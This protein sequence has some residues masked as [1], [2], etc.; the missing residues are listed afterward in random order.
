[1][2]F[3]S[4]YLKSSYVHD[5]ALNFT[6]ATG[7]AG[8]PFEGLTIPFGITYV[9]DFPDAIKGINGA[10]DILKYNVPD[11]NAGI[12]YKGTFGSG[13]KEGAIIYLGF[14][15][16]TARD[17]SIASFMSRALQFFDVTGVLPVTG[18]ETDVKLI[19]N[20]VQ[21]RWTTHTEINTKEFEVEKSSNGV[22]F[23]KIA[24][25]TAAGNSQAARTYSIQDKL[26]VSGIYFYRVKSIDND[27][28]VTYSDVKNVH[29]G[30]DLTNVKIGPNPFKNSLTVSNLIDVKRI[31]LI[32]LTG[33]IVVSKKVTNENS[34]ILQ[35]NKLPAGMY[36]LKTFKTDGNFETIK[37][38]RL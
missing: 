13:T 8:T 38:I 27:G 22:Q 20:N 31:D 10:I 30:Q 36:Q 19:G 1:M 17:S 25:K 5:G 6:P 9:E 34:I 35:T 15:L 4:N 23:Q 24:T 37:V 2:D 32:D 12:A 3:M 26:D 28:R 18:L 29:Y 7:I 33:R 21:I 14:T 11:R 16:E